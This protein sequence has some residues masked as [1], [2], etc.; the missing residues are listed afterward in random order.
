[1]GAQGTERSTN[2]NVTTMTF[3]KVVFIVLG[4]WF[5]WYIR[6]IVAIF[7]VALLLAGL[8]TP[9]AAWFAKHKIPRGIAVLLL[10]LILGAIVVA[11]FTI[12]V[13]VVVEQSKELFTSFS[14][15]LGGTGPVG[16]FFQA[17]VQPHLSAAFSSMQETLSQ[18]VSSVF[19]T[20]KGVV[21]G[22]AALFI[23]LVLTFYMVVEEKKARSYFRNLAPAEYQPYIEHLL[24]KIQVKI[25]AWLQG[26]ILL[27]LIVGCLIF[28]GLS[29]LQVK[30]ALL[31]AII[32]GL[33]E[34]IPYVGPI[35]SVIPAA[36]I[37]FAQSPILGFCVLILYIVIQQLENHV[38]VPKIMQKVTGL[39]PIISIAALLI[40][41]KVGG[42]A[43]AILAIPLATLVVVVLED[44]FKDAQ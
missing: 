42:L 10:Y 34:I 33:L 1:M 38:L 16:D 36:I 7:L 43:G 14:S 39:N 31:L 11:V 20:V 12:L 4:L 24:Q 26:Q 2:V 28:L 35:V 9:L 27:G 8:I 29:L 17:N 21:G 15:S 18:S 25:G 32:A 41:M 5:L 37:A 13:P 19:S 30:Y 23:V 44:L 22:I 40:G 6:D 3:V